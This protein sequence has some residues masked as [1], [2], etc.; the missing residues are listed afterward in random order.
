[1][2][3]TTER[4]RAARLP[5]ARRRNPFVDKLKGLASLLTVLAIVG[6]VP[7]LLVTLFGAPW[8]SQ[9]PDKDFLYSQLGGR[10]QTLARRLNSGIELLAR[11]ASPTLP[12]ASDM[13]V[14]ETT[15]KLGVHR[16]AS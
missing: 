14:R 12:P 15:T 16:M 7:N 5:A 1:M 6:G 3:K 10:S 11:P 9:M 4:P 8:P 13:N 2:V